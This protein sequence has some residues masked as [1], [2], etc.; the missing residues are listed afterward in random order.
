[1]ELAT[2]G[3]VVSNAMNFVVRQQ[4]QIGKIE[5]IKLLDKRMEAIEEEKATEGVF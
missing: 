2:N 1:M 3:A 4:E 5:T